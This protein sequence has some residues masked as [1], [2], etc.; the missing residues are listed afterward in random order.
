V[1]LPQIILQGLCTMAF[2]HKTLVD[3]LCPGRD[4]LRLNRYRVQFARPVLP[5]QKLTFQGAEIGPAE[6][7]GNQYGLIAKNDEGQELLRDA[8]CI[9][10]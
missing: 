8:W 10:A 9:I 4:P 3:N 5:G 2:G 7:G 1:G 6:G